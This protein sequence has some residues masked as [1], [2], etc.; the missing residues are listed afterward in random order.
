MRWGDLTNQDGSDTSIEAQAPEPQKEEP[1]LRL[2]PIVL[3]E[4][5]TLHGKPV[6]NEAKI[7]FFQS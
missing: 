4:P 2:L 3:D 1:L 7:Q 5:K 6:A